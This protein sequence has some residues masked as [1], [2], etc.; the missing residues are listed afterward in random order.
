MVGGQSVPRRL[1][2][3]IGG[4]RVELGL[5]SDL[6]LALRLAAFGRVEY[7][8]EPLVSY[9]IRADSTST[10]L[11]RED[12]ARRDL[13]L[14]LAWAWSVAMHAHATRRTV[15]P[16]EWRSVHGALARAYLQR[17]LRKRLS[18]GSGRVAAMADV[19]HAFRTSPSTVIEPWRLIAAAAAIVAP[20]AAIS[21]AVRVG[22]EHGVV[23][24]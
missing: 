16:A 22:H 15:G 6:E 20:R 14:E 2:N 21:R 17:A 18:R 4:W 7:V 5:H 9:T 13:P 23:M 24:I 8:A 1:L 10:E 19:A 3:E 11:A 12:V